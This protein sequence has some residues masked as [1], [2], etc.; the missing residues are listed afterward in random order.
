MV[1]RVGASGAGM[2]TMHA[3]SGPGGAPRA[4][5]DAPTS[6]VQRSQVLV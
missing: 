5:N 1:A 6:L 3:T 4:A 2:L